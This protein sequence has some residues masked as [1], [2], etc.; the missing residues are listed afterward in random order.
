MANRGSPDPKPARDRPSLASSGSSSSSKIIRQRQGQRE[1]PATTD[2]LVNTEDRLQRARFYNGNV[3]D[4]NNK[5][6]PSPQTSS[7]RCLASKRGTSRW[8]KQCER[9]RRWS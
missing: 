1:F 9:R 6:K 5:V 8:K 7:L 2:Q 3:R 4:L